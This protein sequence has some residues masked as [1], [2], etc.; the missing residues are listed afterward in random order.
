MAFVEM[1]W[2]TNIILV[3]NLKVSLAYSM[4]FYVREQKQELRRPLSR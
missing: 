4:R 2:F 1:W 3:K